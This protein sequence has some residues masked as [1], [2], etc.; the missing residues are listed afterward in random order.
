MKLLFCLLTFLSFNSYGALPTVDEIYAE[1]D[2][3]QNSILEKREHRKFFREYRKPISECIGLPEELDK[4]E[5]VAYLNTVRWG[6]LPYVVDGQSRFVFYG[7]YFIQFRTTA[8]EMQVF[9]D[10]CESY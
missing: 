2:S 9:L 7:T 5:F 10:L 1:F 8:N 3:N 4:L 6:E